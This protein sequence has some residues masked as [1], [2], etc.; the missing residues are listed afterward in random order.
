[1]QS[2][3]EQLFK[4]EFGLDPENM[5]ELKPYNVEEANIGIL[6]YDE[7]SSK[8]VYAKIFNC[9]KKPADESFAIKLEGRD[10]F[11][12]PVSSKHLYAVYIE[13]N[14]STDYEYVK[15]LEKGIKVFTVDGFKKIEDIKKVD[16]EYWLDVQTETENYYT[17]GILSHNS[18]MA[19]LNALTGGYAVN[20]Y[21]STRF[22]VTA[23]E[24]ITKNGE[25]VGIKIKIKNY[26]NKT[27][28][29]NRECLLDVYFKDGDGF[30]KGI[31]GEG[32]Y[33]D[34]LLELGLIKQHGAWYYYHE[35][36]P[37]PSKL[38]KF[39]GWSGVQ[40]W[41]KEHPE[42]FAIVK[43]LVD[44]KM[45]RFDETLDKN[46]VETDEGAEAAAE[47]KL[48]AERKSANTEALAEKA[49][50]EVKEN[51]EE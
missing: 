21:P 3:L 19:H 29:P 25:M 6:A 17:N 27:G 26:K 10:S 1:M 43:T 38:V 42:E 47:S 2:T 14:G 32:Q 7:K 45:A 46:S 50:S 8:N 16:K 31:D 13:E 37:D 9:I 35:D 22:R 36:D 12:E 41:F 24:P 4:L 34:M 20:F 23:R 28:F 39:Q 5:E 44:S 30:K 51:S 15:N 33:L 40:D 49:L 48:E 18:P 11:E